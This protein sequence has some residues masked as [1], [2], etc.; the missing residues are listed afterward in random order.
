MIR[1]NFVRWYGPVCLVIYAS[2]CVV[3]RSVIIWRQTGRSPL[4][5]GQGDSVYD[6]IGH[7]FKF[8][9]ALM[10]T[11]VVA[12]SVPVHVYQYLVP[13]SFLET[14]LLRT[15]GVGLTVIALAWTVVAQAHMGV[16]WRIGI[17]QHQKTSLVMQGL[18]R[19]SRNPIFLGALVAFF[20]FF[21]LMPNAV[22]LLVFV[23]SYVLIQIQVR[24]EEDFLVHVH[25][26][27]YRSYCRHVRRWL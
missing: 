26:E 25:G 2:L 24:L 20:G 5:L 17:D 9:M 4:A 21:M 14:D 22:S 3:W 8:T 10:V 11:V 12:F 16:S 7:W 27:E 13:I 19:Y 1:E 18:F 15:I 6:Y 23:L